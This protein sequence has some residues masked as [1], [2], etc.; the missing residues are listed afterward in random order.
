M[1]LISSQSRGSPNVQNTAQ[2]SFP[3]GSWPEGTAFRINLVSTSSDNQAILAQSSEFNITSS[4]SG[5][6]AVASSATTSATSTGTPP[7]TLAGMRTSTTAMTTPVGAVNGA[8]ASQSGNGLP[9]VGAVSSP[10]SGAMGE[11]L[12]GSGNADNQTTSN[13]ATELV[14]APSIVFTAVIGVAAFFGIY[15]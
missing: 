8:S 6:G 1:T 7:A 14:G 15:A 3:S 12:S 10:P 2:V 11:K 13:A 4:G 9:N 5:S